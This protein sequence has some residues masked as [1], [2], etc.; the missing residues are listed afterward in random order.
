VSEKGARRELLWSAEASDDVGRAVCQRTRSAA[1][2]PVELPSPAFRCRVCSLT[3]RAQPRTEPASERA[4]LGHRTELRTE[5]AHTSRGIR[6]ARMAAAEASCTPTCPRSL[7]TDGERARAR[8][9]GLASSCWTESSSL[10]PSTGCSKALRR[11]PWPSTRSLSTPTATA[12]TP[13]RPRSAAA[14]PRPSLARLPLATAT[15]T[16]TSTRTRRTTTTTTTT[17]MPT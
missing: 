11:S 12:T 2:A 3:A 5:S 13:A 6:R 17:R 1:E 10:S 14:P 7:A 8:R 9:V 4:L 15:A 16:S